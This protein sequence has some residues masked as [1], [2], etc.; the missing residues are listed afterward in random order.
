[1][2]AVQ[3]IAQMS[4]TSRHVLIGVIEVLDPVT[5]RRFR[6]ELHEANGSRLGDYDGVERRLRLHDRKQQRGMQVM[7]LG[8]SSYGTLQFCG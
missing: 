8:R 6:H 3:E 1:M 7:L 2:E 5:H 4:G